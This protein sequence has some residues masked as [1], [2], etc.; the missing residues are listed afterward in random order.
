MSKKRIISSVTNDLLT[1]QRVHRI[2]KSLSNHDF[3]VSL[4]GR[5]KKSSI[6]LEGR[7]YSCKR[8]HLIFEKGPLF[9]M[10]YNLRLFVFLL[11]SN[12]DLL[13]SNDLDSLL[14]NYLV[15]RVRNLPIVYDSHEF[16]TEVPELIK[17]K[18]QSESLKEQIRK[19]EILCALEEGVL[20]I[21]EKFENTP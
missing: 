5:R 2:C 8:F 18:M 3:E 19:Q 16:F 12:V 10:E 21:N 7:S 6:A 1:D 17:R 11:F 4:I 20:F 13:I 14:A 15:S 9:Y